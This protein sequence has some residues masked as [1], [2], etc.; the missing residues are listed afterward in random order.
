MKV[1][2]TNFH[3]SENINGHVTYVR[4]LVE[5]LSDRC[6]FFVASPGGSALNRAVESVD[7][8]NIFNVD[9]SARVYKMIP[10]L[11]KIRKLVVKNGIDIVHVNGSSDHRIVAI[12][13]MFLKNKPKV[14]LTKHNS[15]PIRYI[16]G[17]IKRI[18]GMDGVIAVCSS[19]ERMVRESVY[20]SLKILKIENGVDTDFFSPSGEKWSV[21]G[22]REKQ[23]LVGKIVIGSNAGT[24]RYKGWINMLRALAALGVEERARFHVAVAGGEIGLEE[25]EE[26]K[27]LGLESQ[28]TYAGMLSDV[29]DFVRSIDIG[30]VLSYEVETISFACREMMSCGKPVIVTNYAGLPDNVNENENG[31]IVPVGDV[32]AI[33]KILLSI[34]NNEVD[35]NEMGGKAREKAVKGF[36]MENFV[37]ETE[38][39]Y[40]RVLKG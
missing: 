2:Y 22:W 9:Y 4:L 14:V 31:W 1:L 13:I 25:M 21:E 6:G 16:S 10:S 19:S 34:A 30:F 18:I 40:K 27:V 20:K 38:G 3:K 11:I 7:G 26:I 35:V 24:S 37:L 39:F 36:G 5:G 23:G 29:R 28:F 33:S 8:V 12:A 32:E 15:K 17:L